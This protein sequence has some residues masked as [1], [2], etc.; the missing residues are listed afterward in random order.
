MNGSLFKYRAA[1][2]TGALVEG[3]ITAPSPREAIA[4]LRR[5]T[6]IPVSVEATRSSARSHTRASRDASL[7]DTLRGLASLLGAGVPLDRALEFAATNSNHE[8]LAA[9][10]Q[11]VRQRVRDGEPL[12]AAMGSEGVVDPF[13][14]ALV[15]SG[16]ESGT[17]DGALARLADHH[18]R[19]RDLRAQIRGALLYPALMAVVAG[20]GVVVLMT[21]VVPRFSALLAD[22]GGSLPWSTRALVALSQA[23]TRW[24]WLW[25]L[26]GSL[27]ALAM[28][29]WLTDSQ[30]RRQW[31]SA[32]LGLPLVGRLEL[33]LSA[34]R[35]A[36]AL[37]VL[38]Q[39]G[40]GM[41]AAMRLA[42]GV[43]TN[44]ALAARLEQATQ[45]VADGKRLG[46][47]LHDIL[48]GTV[49]QLIAVGEESGRLD[50][51]S[52]RAA[53]AMDADVE[54]QLKTLVG[55]VE[56]VLI[57]LFGS[58]V[59]FVALALVQAIYAINAGAIL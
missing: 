40:V 23:V 19:V 1:T 34:A 53:D 31:H 47:A 17:L 54:R 37:G 59:G 13:G 9:S 58:V 55:L 28:R 15:R 45:A 6:L 56:P 30:H 2:A 20:V 35:Y 29:R 8:A 4:E 27:V 24:W 48:P 11:K 38:L 18:E 41:L 52:V 5:Q 32:R 51:L 44:A 42:R 33:K 39:S 46:S 36:R 12:A 49:V 43:V 10:L 16:E 22:V 14:A 50:E 21:F 26:L 57:V 25:L 3:T 7:A